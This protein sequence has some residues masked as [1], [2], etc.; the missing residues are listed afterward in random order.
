MR[1]DS[2]HHVWVYRPEEHPWIG[3]TL[4]ALRRDYLIDEFEQIL[5]SAGYAGSVVVQ[6]RQS[7]EETRW[8]LRQA[9]TRPFLRA[10][11]GWI[12]LCSSRV[13]ERLQDFLP[14]PKLVGFRHNIHNESDDFT[15]RKDF[16]RGLGVLQR[17]GLA[18]DLLI[19]PRHLPLVEPLVDEFP[20]LTLVI[21]HLAKPMTDGT[22]LVAW[23]KN[24]GRLAASPRVSIKLSGLSS[25]TSPSRWD[26][27]SIRFL[28]D[29]AW[30]A[31][32]PERMMAASNWPVSNLAGS[33]AWTMG[34]VEDFLL[35]HGARAADLVLG[36]NAER[37]YRLRSPGAMRGRGP[38][39][40][41]GIS[42]GPG[43]SSS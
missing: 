2:H 8:L 17:Y 36:G 25:E 35:K 39:T 23:K 3:P 27:T 15:R 19:F 16:R 40:R 30:E 42:R 24:L 37:I 4:T 28:L 20:D 31:F 41:P 38:E 6:A 10:V 21:D 13:E 14:E 9:K 22:D 33:Y 29:A 34:L 5:H 7:M 12:D 26:M 1:I 32:G 11:V 18:Y 43:P